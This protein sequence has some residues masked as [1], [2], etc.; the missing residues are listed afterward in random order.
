MRFSS[1]FCLLIFAFCLLPF[2]SATAQSTDIPALIGRADVRVAYDILDRD[3]D[4]FLKEM[5]ELV[6]VPAPSFK[7][8]ARAKVVEAK[9]RECGL[10]NVDRDPEGNVIGFRPGLGGGPNLV[11]AAHLDTVFP[12]GT[13]VQVKKEGSRY[14]A[15]GIGDD[16]HGLATLLA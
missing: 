12:E 8:T 9:F 15:P 2:S 16:V 14:S 5:V 6:E 7:E 1:S 11:L 10:K 4:R 13:N 3:F